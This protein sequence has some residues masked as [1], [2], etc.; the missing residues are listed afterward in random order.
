MKNIGIIAIVLALLA[1]GCE[2]D[3]PEVERPLY[4][5]E[6]AINARYTIGDKVTVVFAKGNLQYQASSRTWRF[7]SNQYDVVGYDNELVDTTYNGWIDLFGWGT[8]GEYG[9]IPP[10]LADSSEWNG[11]MPYTVVDSNRWYAF[12]RDDIGGSNYDWGVR[13]VISNGGN[14]AG[15]WRTM[16][17]D[18]WFYLLKYRTN[19]VKKKA[20]ATIENVGL[21]GAAM[22]GMLLLPDKWELPDGCD[23]QYGTKNGFETNVYSVDQWNKM[24]G[25]GAVFL[26]AAGERDGV[27]VGMVGDYGCYW[28]TTGYTLESAYELYFLSSG[29]AFYPTNRAT[30]HSVRLVME[31]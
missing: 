31:R 4:P 7:A 6:G 5:A 10:S 21:Q 22:H 9:T 13:N 29:Y 11:L 12:G 15:M 17:Y 19:A 14:K 23:F 18:E 1:M 26:P 20:L 28:T 25:A 3:G 30:G 2:S 8:S 16:T 27:T 24:Q